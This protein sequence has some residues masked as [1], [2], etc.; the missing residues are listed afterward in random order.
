MLLSPNINE[1]PQIF[2]H[3]SGNGYGNFYDG[4]HQSS[5]IW[6]YA[7]VYHNKRLRKIEM[8]LFLRIKCFAHKF[9]ALRNRIYIPF[10]LEE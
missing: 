7:I 9:N 3:S 5:H 10:L 6:Y 2:D 8:N 4:G 1:I